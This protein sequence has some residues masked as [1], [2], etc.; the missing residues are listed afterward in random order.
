MATECFA[1][2]EEL[3][4][5]YF[6]ETSEQLYEVSAISIIFLLLGMM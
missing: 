5:D 3:S 2:A 4:V 1:H 6:T